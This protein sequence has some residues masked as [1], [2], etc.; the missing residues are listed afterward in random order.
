MGMPQGFVATV[1]PRLNRLLLGSQDHEGKGGL[2]IV[3]II[4]DRLL[5]PA[6]D[7]NAAAEV[8]EKAGSERLGP[9]L[10]QLL[11]A[12]AAR[13]G[14]AGHAG[15]IQSLILVFARL[16]LVAPQDVVSFLADVDLDGQNGLQVVISKWLESSINFAG[17]DDIRQNVMALTKLYNLH[18][19]RLLSIQ[20]KGDMI[21][22]QSDRIMTRSRARQQPDQYTSVP[23]QLKIIKVLVEELLSAS[24]NRPIDPSSAAD[25]DD[26][27]ED[28]DGDWED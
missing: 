12:V 3:L 24:G 10:M 25:L 14:S 20:V 6:V 23:A 19:P 17:Y 22:P 8:V 28:G 9:Y 18:D 11:R 5:N 26:D 2:E 21:M 27:E 4:I 1:M 7:D 15:F 13:L 16:S